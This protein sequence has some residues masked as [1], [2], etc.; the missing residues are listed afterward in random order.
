MSVSEDAIKSETD[1]LPT[2]TA[3]STS[4]AGKAGSPTELAG[5]KRSRSP[6]ERFSDIASQLR[7]DDSQSQCAAAEQDSKP[8]TKSRSLEHVH[9]ASMHTLP[10]GHALSASFREAYTAFATGELATANIFGEIKRD[11]IVTYMEGKD[12][13]VFIVDN[14]TALWVPTSFIDF[15]FGMAY[16]ISERMSMIGSRLKK[17]LQI[18]VEMGDKDGKIQ[19][20]G[21]VKRIEKA[22]LNVQSTRGSLAIATAAFQLLRVKSLDIFDASRTLI[23]FKS[24][25]YD[26]ERNEFRPRSSEDRMTAAL[27]YDV[28]EVLIEDMKAIETFFWNIFEDLDTM[29]AVQALCAYWFTGRT[30][31]KLF[32]QLVNQSNCGKT[33]FAAIVANALEFY[34]SNGEVPVSELCHHFSGALVKVLARHPPVRLIIVDEIGTT[35]T[36]HSRVL[37]DSIFNVL[38]DGMESDTGKAIALNQKFN[39]GQKVGR[40]QA[41]LLILSNGPMC[42][43]WSKSGLWTRSLSLPMDNVFQV[44]P[45]DPDTSPLNY[46][47]ADP[48]LATFLQSAEARPGIAA[49]IINGMKL[50]YGP[51]T[52]RTD[53]VGGIEAMRAPLCIQAVTFD[54]LVLSDPYARYLILNFVPTGRCSDHISFEPLLREFTKEFEHNKPIIREARNGFTAVIARLSDYL[55][56]KTLPCSFGIDLVVT[57]L[58]PRTSYDEPWFK[59][60]IT[61]TVTRR[62]ERAVAMYGPVGNEIM[63]QV[64]QRAEILSGQA[65][66]DGNKYFGTLNPTVVST[67]NSETRPV[68]LCDP[69]FVR[70]LARAAVQ[71]VRPF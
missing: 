15:Q 30:H 35:G 70:I 66:D 31:L 29:N 27:S 7:D 48:D 61:A 58:K 55:E 42:I 4:I 71:R 3:S 68:F 49:W 53:C 21:Y 2:L 67:V 19:W 37:N 47:K 63:K 24:E 43:P 20:G 17:E 5:S 36:D 69:E 39:D 9:A 40:T 22:L 32:T 34:A 25:V 23:S 44:K 62:H 54:T 46:R 51:K 52:G 56:M 12:K 8:Q 28:S 10:P 1:V 57:G 6:N 60:A 11:C 16:W 13:R 33:T 45:F 41:K 50:L 59:N 18:F 64:E 65:I 38:A 14:D 26:C